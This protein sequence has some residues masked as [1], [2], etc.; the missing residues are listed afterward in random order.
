[1]GN[2]TI[3]RTTTTDEDGRRQETTDH[4][5]NVDDEERMGNREIWHIETTYLRQRQPLILTRVIRVIPGF[6]IAAAEA[7]P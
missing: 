2:S 4:T 5:D 7:C 1:M 6:P 3:L